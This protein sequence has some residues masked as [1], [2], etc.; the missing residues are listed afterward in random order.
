MIELCSRSTLNKTNS[1]PPYGLSSKIKCV[2]IVA[3]KGLK[4]VY[5]TFLRAN[6]TIIMNNPPT[7]P[8]EQVTKFDCLRRLYCPPPSLPR[9]CEHLIPF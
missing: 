9:F 2:T 4:L 7:P 6:L 3:L 5:E 8:H 1:Q